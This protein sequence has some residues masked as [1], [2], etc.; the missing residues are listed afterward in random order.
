VAAW[1]WRD[2]P[3]EGL[4]QIESNGDTYHF[5]L[6]EE[7]MG[8]ADD[9]DI[10]VFGLYPVSSDCLERFVAAVSPYHEP[11]WPIWWPTWQFPSEEILKQINELVDDIKENAGPLA[12][13]IASDASFRSV[14][15]FSIL[16][17]APTA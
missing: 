9:D 7:R 4:L 2:G 13:I 17:T 8:D 10:R 3:T 6:L 15:A 5:R 12:W 1:D 16:N 11:R 14:R